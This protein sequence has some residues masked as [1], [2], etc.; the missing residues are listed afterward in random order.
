MIIATSPRGA[1]PKPISAESRMLLRVRSAEPPHASTLE[2]MAERDR[3]EEEDHA[4][5]K[6]SHVGKDAE[7]NTRRRNGRDRRAG[8][9]V[10]CHSVLIAG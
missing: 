5:G 9:Q 2:T 6:R 10:G 8:S 4:R 1:I 3:S 7:G